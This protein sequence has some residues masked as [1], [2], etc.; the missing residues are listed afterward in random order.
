MFIMPER[1]SESITSIKRH[2]DGTPTLINCSI[3]EG[4]TV[5]NSIIEGYGTIIID[6]NFINEMLTITNNNR[7][8]SNLIE[9][10]MRLNSIVNDYFYSSSTNN[11]SR[12]EIYEEFAVIDSEGMLTGTKI[13]SLKGK[14]VALCSEKSIAVYILNKNLYKKGIIT[15]KPTMI[16]STLRTEKTSNEPHAFVLI[17]KEDDEYPTKHLL[18]DIQ[19]PTLLEDELGKRIHSLGLYTISDEQYNNIINGF[20]CTPISLFEVM[21]QDLHDVGDKRIYGSNVLNISI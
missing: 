4:C 19:N 18:Y 21:R 3:K 16:L 9:L 12:I 5:E 1:I 6:K 11:K 13:S 15:R 8:P 10:L 7:L 2:I 17:D 20:E 14:N